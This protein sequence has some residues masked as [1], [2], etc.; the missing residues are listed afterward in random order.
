MAKGH[1]YHVDRPGKGKVGWR[2]GK[3]NGR[4]VHTDDVCR[5]ELEIRRPGDRQKQNNT[6]A[7][8]IG[9]DIS[10]HHSKASVTRTGDSRDNEPKED[11]SQHFFRQPA[12]AAEASFIPYEFLPSDFALFGLQLAS[13]STC[14]HPGF[15]FLPSGT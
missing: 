15:I 12:D 8:W 9:R 3:G 5:G 1:T 11:K 13:D 14:A 4:V 2:S 7:A 6:Q 10:N